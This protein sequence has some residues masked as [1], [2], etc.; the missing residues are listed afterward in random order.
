[1]DTSWHMAMPASL[2]GSYRIEAR[3]WDAMGHTEPPR[4]PVQAWS[5]E[6]DTLVPRVTLT[7]SASGSTYHYTATAQDYNLVQDG[8]GTPCPAG[9]AVAS[10]NFQ[11]PWYVAA[12]PTSPRLYQLKVEC[13]LN[14]PA[15]PETA[16]ACDSFGNCS[17]CD[18]AGKC[19][20]SVVTTPTGAASAPTATTG[21]QPAPQSA[22]TAPTPVV[23]EPGG[24][25]AGP[26]AGAALGKV[27]PQVAR[28]QAAPMQPAV[29]F[30][31]TVI[32]STHLSS[33]SVI[34]ITG[35]VTNT[36][37]IRFVVGRGI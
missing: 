28:A 36:N 11:S 18:T 23:A 13:T 27:Q 12:F 16:K 24:E 19:T 5:G 31:P 25:A 15:S 29:V 21:S 26:A 20:T 10:T 1:M 33:P 6:A 30:A 22:G 34:D 14:S 37:V 8:L 9:A 2:E 32:T 35:L 3:G 7:R 4:S 17:T